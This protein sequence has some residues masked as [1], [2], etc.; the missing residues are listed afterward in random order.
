MTFLEGLTKPTVVAAT[1]RDSGVRTAGIGEA[2]AGPKI[3]LE[4]QV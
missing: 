4:E 1:C 2:A 3:V